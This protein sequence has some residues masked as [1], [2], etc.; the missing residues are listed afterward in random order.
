MSGKYPHLQGANEFAGNNGRVFEQ[1]ENTYD[2]DAYHDNVT[3]IKLANVRWTAASTDRVIWDDL[4]A[5][6]TWLDG[7]AGHSVE[8]ESGMNFVGGMTVKL[9]IPYQTAIRY[10]YMIVDTPQTPVDYNANRVQR[11]CYFIESAEYYN[12]SVTQFTIAIDDVS[13]YQFDMTLARIDLARGHYPMTLTDVESYLGAPATRSAG[14]LTPE[15][16][17]PDT[18]GIYSA[19]E[20]VPLV[21]GEMALLFALRCSVKQLADLMDA[22][23]RHNGTPPTFFD[24]AG[25]DGHGKTVRGNIYPDTGDYSALDTPVGM[26]M[27]TGDLVP[28]GY[29][30][31]G[32]PYDGQFLQYMSDH[33]PQFFNLV[34][35]MYV[36]PADYVTYGTQYHIGDKTYYRIGNAPDAI[37]SRIKLSRDMFGYPERYANIAKLY[38]TPYAAIRV[39]DVNG[40]NAII[41]IQDMTGSLNVARRVSIIYPYLSAELF[42]TGIGANETVQYE[43]RDLRN[44]P[45]IANIPQSDYNFIV[46]FDIPTYTIF[47]NANKKEYLDNYNAR[48]MSASETAK[49]A[50]TNST[51]SANIANFNA[52]KSA[53]NAQTVGDASALTA[54]NNAQASASTAQ[55]NANASA[56]TA[57][58][59]ATNSANTAKTN[60]ANVT[61]NA[62]TITNKTNSKLREDTGYQTSLGRTLNGD[63]TAYQ[64]ALYQ[65]EEANA[66]MSGVMGGIANIAQGLAT[67]GPMGAAGALAGALANGVQTSLALNAKSEQ[68]TATNAFNDSMLSDTNTTT[69]NSMELS[70]KYNNE[71]TTE[72][73]N[74][75]NTNATNVQQTTITN[76]SNSAATARANAQRSQ[77]TAS[78]NANSTYTTATA[79]NLKTYNTSTNNAVRARDN[80]VS[81]N[82][83]NLTLAYNNAVRG[84]DD[85]HR[86]APVTI[87]PGTG[88]AERMIYHN[89]GILVQI[90]TQQPDKIARYGDTFL[91][92]GYAYAHTVESPRMLCNRNFTYWEGSAVIYSDTAPASAVDTYRRLLSEGLTF[93]RDGDKIGSSI[94]DNEVVQ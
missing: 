70:V 25:N 51:T 33:Y 53:A 71:C 37:I 29:D 7:L 89:N 34:A 44:T 57:Q 10:N 54:K 68:I 21:S 91:R 1:Y 92:Y 62:T 39:S 30:V 81:N 2:Y 27:S 65:I 16:E 26:Q 50:Y 55:S 15:P 9:P 67:G 38:T 82:Q 12:A 86:R 24:A 13:T 77:T 47:W 75:I 22:G 8:L 43:W 5:R 59:N 31:I 90:L 11:L 73:N 63:K 84:F 49:T 58:S 20:F 18:P 41:S 35:A 4:N 48:T 78:N 93:W 79:N 19:G 66:A 83:N 88:N 69:N 46:R 61:D 72:N 45:H 14:L 76:A 56:N 60:T 32:L 3:K 36:V 6:D 74:V 40:A 23:A 52:E 17:T 94:Y 42:V 85:L 87:T 28:N 64:Q 80:T